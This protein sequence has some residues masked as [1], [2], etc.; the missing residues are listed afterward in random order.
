MSETVDPRQLAADKR[1]AREERIHRLR[2]R[3]AAGA[4]ALFVAA[5]AGLYVQLVSGND[6]ALAG[7]VTPVSQ[8]ADPT[9]TADSSDDS[10]SDDGSADTWTDDTGSTDTTQ[11]A[12]SSQPDAVSTG[13][14]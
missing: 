7:D 4:V 13:Q 3:I 14:S 9:A 11:S 2:M 6:P 5:W 1:R 12:S 8:S 10:W